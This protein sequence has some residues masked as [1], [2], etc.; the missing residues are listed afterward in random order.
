[1]PIIKNNIFQYKIK[2]TMMSNK[3]DIVIMGGVYGVYDICGGFVQ[4]DAIV[5]CVD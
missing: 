2:E 5:I 3:D 4:N 1:M